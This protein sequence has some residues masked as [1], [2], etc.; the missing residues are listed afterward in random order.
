MSGWEREPGSKTG[1][2]RETDLSLEFLHLPRQLGHSRLRLLL[3]AVPLS[4]LLNQPIEISQLVPVF[5]S[6]PFNDGELRGKLVVRSLRH[7]RFQR[8]ALFGVPQRERVAGG[9]REN[10]SLL[11]GVAIGLGRSNRA[12]T[13][14]VFVVVVVD[15]FARKPNVIRFIFC[16]RL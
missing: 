4:L 11:G 6:P 15:V 14:V 9:R 2:V 12:E 16:C 1:L 13:G 8:S 5:G 10:G 3:D 7:G